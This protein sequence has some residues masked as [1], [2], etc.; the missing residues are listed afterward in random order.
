MNPASR[1]ARAFRTPQK[2]LCAAEVVSGS[3]A[4][5]DSIRSA[6]WVWQSIS[7]GVTV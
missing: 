7:P 1:V 2:A 4:L 5:L 6:M 3:A